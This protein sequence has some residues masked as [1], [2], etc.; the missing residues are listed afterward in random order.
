M[1]NEKKVVDAEYHKKSEMLNAKKNGSDK[2]KFS[3]DLTKS[4]KRALDKAKEATGKPYGVIINDIIQSV[5]TLSPEEKNLWIR[6][7]REELDILN[8]KLKSVPKGGY[9]ED[10]I[11]YK[12]S[13]MSA[14]LCYMNEKIYNPN[15]YLKLDDIIFGGGRLI[16]PETWI[17]LNPSDA[18]SS[19]SATRVL[20]NLNNERY[21]MEEADIPNVPI[22][23][24][25]HNHLNSNTDSISEQEKDI[26]Y[27][28]CFK[29]WD[30]LYMLTNKKIEF[31]FAAVPILGEDF[32][33]SDPTKELPE[34]CCIIRPNIGKKHK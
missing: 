25:Y 3:L 23:I 9:M 4:S 34:H 21:F 17:I 20:C 8:N 12:I 32:D 19:Q 14:L 18:S 15:G 22:F 24:F 16:V 5:L 33:Y 6:F 30:N 7:Y 28:L 2:I 26:I 10:S 1:K 31:K 11:L 29:H 27:K 13:K